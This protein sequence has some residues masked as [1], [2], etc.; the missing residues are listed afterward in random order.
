MKK[1]I[2]SLFVLVL[3]ISGVTNLT[4][5]DNRLTLGVKG[6]INLSTLSMKD[7]PNP[8]SKVGFNLGLTVDY[9][10]GQRVYLLTGLEINTKGGKWKLYELKASINQ[11]YLQ[12]PI[13]VGYKFE[14]TESTKL[15]L[16]AGPYLAYGIGG[17]SKLEFE[18]QEEKEDTFGSDGLKK[19]DVGI[20]LGFG[21]EFNQMCLGLGYDLGLYNISG[22]EESA[23]NRNFYLS[24][25]YKF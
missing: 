11:V 21:V 12:L 2:K 23:K 6:G 14:I 7:I 18:G 16:H 25:G 8:D 9:E 13:H 15:V 5:Q 3:L 17:K 10:L 1:T 24:I 4:A 19:F 20:G 22:E